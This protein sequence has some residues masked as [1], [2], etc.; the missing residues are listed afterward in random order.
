MRGTLSSPLESLCTRCTRRARR[1]RCTAACLVPP[2][3]LDRGSMHE[4]RST[5]RLPWPFA[6]APEAVRIDVLDHSRRQRAPHWG[7]REEMRAHTAATYIFRA[8]NAY[9]F[10][11]PFP[12]ER[13]NEM[14]MIDLRRRRDR[15]FRIREYFYMYLKVPRAPLVSDRR[16]VGTR[17]PVSCF[18]T[19]NGTCVNEL[20]NVGE[21]SFAHRR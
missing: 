15:Q 20:V 13:Q 21:G 11:T 7:G 5:A 9:R 4:R 12:V 8:A 1:S 2:M 18:S 3:W 16:R 17:P 14:N 6:V 10:S 19:R